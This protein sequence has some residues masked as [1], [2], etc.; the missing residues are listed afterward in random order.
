MAYNK[1]NFTVLNFNQ[2]TTPNRFAYLTTDAIATVLAAGYFNAL[3]DVLAV[4]DTI[5][6]T[7]SNANTFVKVTA[8]AAK[9]VTIAD[10]VDFA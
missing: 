2:S 9:V 6:V 3:Y 7:A 1:S 10:G 8:N 4:N 5:M